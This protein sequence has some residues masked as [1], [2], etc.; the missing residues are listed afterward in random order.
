MRKDAA[1]R[2][3]IVT[4]LEKQ[5]KKGDKSLVGNKGFRRFLANGDGDGFAVNRAKIEEDAKY[6]GVFVL[7]TNAGLSPLQTMLVAGSIWFR[8]LMI[9]AGY[10]DGDDADSRLRSDVQDGARSD[11]L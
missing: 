9:A 3:A 5:L 7:R 6:D 1:D 8:L 4:A 11:A 2:A 10:E